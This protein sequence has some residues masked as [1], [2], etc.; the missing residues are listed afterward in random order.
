MKAPACATPPSGLPSTV[1]WPPSRRGPR[2]RRDAG[3]RLVHRSGGSWTWSSTLISATLRRH[4]EA[5]DAHRVLVQQLLAVLVRHAV[6]HPLARV[7]GSRAA[8]G[9]I[10]EV[11][12][13]HQ[14]VDADVVPQLDA[15]VLEPEV[16]EHLAAHGV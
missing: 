1:Q 3:R 6:Q 7:P 11:G 13:P 16:H 10:W 15:L 2:S 5:I 9:D 8:G 12:L 4:L 14:V